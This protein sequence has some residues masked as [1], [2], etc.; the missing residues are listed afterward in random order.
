MSTIGGRHR[1]SYRKPAGTVR[2]I[3]K[4]TGASS[5][6]KSAPTF[7]EAVDPSYSRGQRAAAESFQT[8]GEA[9]LRTTN[10]DASAAFGGG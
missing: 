10:P 9:H 6:Q 1:M 3:A 2:A 7:R 5:S 4:D 8:N